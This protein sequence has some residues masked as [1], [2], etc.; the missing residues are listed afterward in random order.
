MIKRRS[1]SIRGQGNTKQQRVL[2]SS[3]ITIEK[4]MS[5]HVAPAGTDAETKIVRAAE[6]IKQAIPTAKVLFYLNS[7]MDWD[8]YNLHKTMEAHPEN[9]LKDD[10]GDYVKVVGQYVFDHSKESC[11]E[12]WLDTLVRAKK[13]G[14]IDGAFLDRGNYYGSSVRHLSPARQKA[15][16]EGHDLIEKGAQE[17]FADGVVILN[18]ANN[19]DVRNR[20]P[21][22]A[23]E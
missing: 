4:G 2:L 17:I 6:Q 21:H 11:R 15:W 18:N 3:Q 12:Y 1:A 23:C 19:P 10:N 8:M 13:S 22:K 5:S 9:W 16:D 7:I 14:A 20:K